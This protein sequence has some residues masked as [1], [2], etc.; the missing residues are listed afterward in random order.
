MNFIIES[1]TNNESKITVNDSNNF[2]Y[3]DCLEYTINLSLIINEIKEKFKEI[4]DLIYRV[5]NNEFVYDI[6]NG[7]FYDHNIHEQQGLYWKKN[8]YINRHINGIGL[9]LY[10]LNNFYKMEELYKKSVKKILAVKK[11]LNMGVVYYN[12]GSAQ[13]AQGNL[14]LAYSNMI[15]AFQSDQ[16]SNINLDNWL[17]EAL[18]R[19]EFKMVK[20]FLEKMFKEYNKFS[21]DKFDFNI[22]KNFCLKIGNERAFFILKII[23]SYLINGK[24]KNIAIKNIM[25]RNI[26]DLCLFYDD[27]LSYFG[28]IH[29][30]IEVKSKIGA[31]KAFSNK[32]ILDFQGYGLFYNSMVNHQEEWIQFLSS[33]R[34]SLRYNRDRYKFLI[35][36]DNYPDFNSTI[37]KLL[38]LRNKFVY[39]KPF[40]DL[41]ARFICIIR[42]VRN[43]I[44]HNLDTFDSNIILSRSYYSFIFKGILFL[45][46]Y[47]YRYLTNNNSIT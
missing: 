34:Y 9:F 26:W 42:S 10:E 30:I 17:G 16:K 45:I 8:E 11:N 40:Q 41:I 27:L 33:Q 24:S 29:K 20:F 5:L 13:I 1:L 25:F 18:C 46:F 44:A 3:I 38:D 15:R 2:P 14:D 39:S 35:L 6:Q 32:I 37:L 23:H 47:T 28:N 22:F 19:E 4:D 43:H 7:F 21:K 12:L 36:S 31:A